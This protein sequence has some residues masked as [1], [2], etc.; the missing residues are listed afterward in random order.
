MNHNQAL[1]AAIVA[2]GLDPRN[3]AVRQSWQAGIEK[4]LEVRNSEAVAW[5][6]AIG[7][8]EWDLAADATEATRRR[9]FGLDVRPLFLAPSAGGETVKALRSALEASQTLINR[10]MHVYV[11]PDECTSYVK[12]STQWFWDNGGTLAAIAEQNEINRSALTPSS[13]TD[14]EKGR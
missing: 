6:Y 7:G 9:D 13:E 11:A 2:A 14:K 12:A 5:Q 4:Y 3:P 10:L 1:D 8:D